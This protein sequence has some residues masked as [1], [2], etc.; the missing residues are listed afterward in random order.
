MAFTPLRR[1]EFGLASPWFPSTEPPGL[2]S[3]LPRERYLLIIII[4]D[5]ETG[6]PKGHVTCLRSRTLCG[7]GPAGCRL[8][9]PI[10][11]PSFPR[12]MSS[13]SPES[14]AAAPEPPGTPASVFQPVPCAVAPGW[15]ALRFSKDL[16]WPLL[17]TAFPSAVGVF[18]PTL[19]PETINSGSIPALSTAHKPVLSTCRIE[20]MWTRHGPSE[21]IIQV[22]QLSPVVLK[23]YLSGRGHGLAGAHHH[24]ILLLLV[25]LLCHWHTFYLPHKKVFLS[26]VSSL[27]LKDK[28]WDAG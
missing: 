11:P 13:S 24:I 27:C 12:L 1:C 28:L 2:R 8:W 6:A 25:L 15:L 26:S 9:F 22:A 18:A 4:A 14:F 21:G 5:G 20:A 3:Q 16:P 10:K 19:W 7:T 23:I 17:R